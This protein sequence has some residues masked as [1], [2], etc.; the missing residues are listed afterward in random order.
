[1]QRL[2]LIIS[3]QPAFSVFW[4]LVR[5]IRLLQIRPVTG[6]LALK[7]HTVQL[8][9]QFR[10]LAQPV[11]SPIKSVRSVLTTVW[12]V[13]LA[14]S[15]LSRHQVALRLQSKRLLRATSP[16]TRSTVTHLALHLLAH[17]VRWALSRSLDVQL[18][19]T[20]TQT[21]KAAVWSVL[22]ASTVC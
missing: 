20:R 3:A 14:T 18:A 17:T 9:H 4:V 13:H 15:V 12:T 8:E 2:L 21:T 11:R 1:M 22:L 16:A 7:A 10:S 19:S 5:P 6:D